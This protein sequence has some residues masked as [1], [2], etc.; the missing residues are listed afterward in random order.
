MHLCGE[1]AREERE[2]RHGQADRKDF[3]FN[4]TLFVGVVSRATEG[5]PNLRVP[6][7][8]GTAP[9]KMAQWAEVLY[10]PSVCGP[11]PHE[12]SSFRG[13]CFGHEYCHHRCE[14]PSQGHLRLVCVYTRTC[15]LAFS[16]KHAC[17]GRSGLFQSSSLP[18]LVFK[19]GS[20]YSCHCA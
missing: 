15:L 16:G 3:Q 7:G 18:T 14:R 10:S 20:H 6:N 12:R 11:C 1:G 17:G 5:H 9:E 2:R 8:N 4:W 13:P 19:A